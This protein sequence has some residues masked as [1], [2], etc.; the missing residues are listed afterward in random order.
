VFGL[1]IGI[2]LI[3][4]GIGAAVM[5]PHY[6]RTRLA[7]NRAT[8]AMNLRK[9]GGALDLYCMENGGNFPNTFGQLMIAQK[10]Q[11]DLFVCPAS[12]QIPAPGANAKAQADRLTFGRY[13]SY[14]YTGRGL[15]KRTGPGAGVAAVVAYE[16]LSNHGDGVH[17]LF[18][19]GH[20]AFVPEPKATQLITDVQAGKNPTSVTGF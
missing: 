5:I 4:C 20:V 13:L 10:L 9:I 17:V 19:D 12:D 14:A 11:A 6:N 1:M 3:A 16:R 7:A 8:C 15:N 2:V 18:A